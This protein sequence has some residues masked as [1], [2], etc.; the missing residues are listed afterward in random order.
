MDGLCIP[1]TVHYGEAKEKTVSDPDRLLYS[2]Q[3]LAPYWGT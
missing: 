3:A 1:L 2:I